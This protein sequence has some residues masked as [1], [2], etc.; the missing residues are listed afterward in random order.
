MTNEAAAPIKPHT[1]SWQ[2][3]VFSTS[4]VFSSR[5]SY[6]EVSLVQTHWLGATHF[7]WSPQ[8]PSSQLDPDS[9]EML[10][11]SP[12]VTPCHLGMQPNLQRP[13]L[14]KPSPTACWFACCLHLP[15]SSTPRP[16]SS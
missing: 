16:F 6:L 15:H 8:M 1:R 5:I 13:V 12:F 2:Q 9:A 4:P 7:P 11:S 3:P 10:F 14:K